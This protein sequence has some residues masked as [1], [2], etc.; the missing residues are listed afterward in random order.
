MMAVS[1]TVELA[2][3]NSKQRIDPLIE[4]REVLRERIKERRKPG[5]RQHGALQRVRGWGADP[6][7]ASATSSTSQPGQPGTG[8][9]PA[10]AEH[11]RQNQ[12]DRGER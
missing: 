9:R 5:Q 3:R 1:P 12:P 11:Q 7:T 8:R 6:K 2:K 4:E 10:Q